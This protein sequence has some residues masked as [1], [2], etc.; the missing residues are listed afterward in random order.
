MNEDIANHW[1]L[2]SWS[3]HHNGTYYICAYLKHSYQSVLTSVSIFAG[4]CIIQMMNID[5][6]YYWWWKLNNSSLFIHVTF[7]IKNIIDIL[8]RAHNI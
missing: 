3:Q 7:V 5:S 2:S 8:A 6:N 1:C 4:S